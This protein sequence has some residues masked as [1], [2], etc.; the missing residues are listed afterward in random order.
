MKHLSLT[1]SPN[2][3]FSSPP[4]TALT[5]LFRNILPKEILLGL[6][7]VS[8][9]NMLL[10]Y[11]DSIQ[12]NTD[13]FQYISTENIDQLK[14]DSNTLL[15]FDSTFEGYGIPD[16]MVAKSLESSCRSHGV[17]PKKVFIFSGNLLK[18]D[19]IVN[20]IPTYLI[21]LS[22]KQFYDMLKLKDS[23][24]DCNENYDKIILSLSRRNR[25]ER[26]LA[27]FMLYKSPLNNDCVMSQ[28]RLANDFS[29]SHRDLAR[30]NYTSEDF[31]DFKNNLPII[32]DDDNFNINLPFDPLIELH[33]KTLFSIVNETLIS[34]YGNTS[35]FFSEKILKPILN[36]QPMLVY[37]QPGANKNL[38]LL[39]F[40]NY[41]SYFDI[42]FD[43]EPDDI[44]RYK[45]LLAS[46]TDTVNYL[47]SLTRDNQIEWRYKNTELLQF[48]YNQLRYLVA[49]EE[50]M[51][52]FIELVKQIL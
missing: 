45:K 33:S 17:N 32:A 39:G 26:V 41:E 20:I 10:G 50:Q 28:D 34:N 22:F 15:F 5:N 1:Y 18:V 6:E 25:F 51:K 29:I 44:L 12:H 42:S 36:Y 30:M 11:G 47:K 23:Q 9:F 8:Y 43:D 21:H 40:K 31:L 35:L 14:N 46:A 37:G 24:H 7:K 3:F 13:L 16:K 2:P 48:N 38:A 27:Q 52:K 19:S 49:L 4:T